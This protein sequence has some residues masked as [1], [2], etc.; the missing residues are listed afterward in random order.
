MA[1]IFWCIIAVVVIAGAFV[2][3]CVLGYVFGIVISCEED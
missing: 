2:I 1:T 3:G